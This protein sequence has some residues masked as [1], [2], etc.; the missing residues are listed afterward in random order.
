M[1]DKVKGGL[2]VKTVK[3]FF[4]N[5]LVL[6]LTSVFMRF[7]SVVFNV[8]I[9][10]RIGSAGMGLFSLILSVYTF[11]TTLATSGIYLACTR[12]VT[13]ELVRN[14]AQGVKASM[15]KCIIYSLCF[16]TVSFLL[17]FCFAEKIALF[18]LCDIRALRSL[19]LLAVS[20]PFFAL[21]S[22]LSGYFCAVRRVV[23]NALTNI[24]EQFIRI[25][26]TV[27]LLVNTTCKNVEQATVAV[28]IGMCASEILAFLASFI[29]FVAD[30]KKN[31]SRMPEKAS[32][33]IT[34]RL[35]KMSIP[36]ALSAYIR[37][38][39][40]TVENILIP[41]GLIRSGAATEQALSSYG[42]ISGMVFPVIFFP[43]AFLSA[44]SSLVVPEI[45]RY[46]E[47][48][49]RKQIDYVVGRIFKI[50]AVFSVG[51]AGIFIFFSD[52]LGLLLYNSEQA[53]RYIKIF[54]ALIPVMYIDNTTDAV[55][56]GMGEQISS[57]RYNIIDALVSVLL[58]YFLLPPLGIKGYVAVI[59]IS[60]LLNASL[61]LQRMLRITKIKI[62]PFSCIVS[63]L[64][65]IIG[66]TS[67][68]NIIKV[69]YKF[70]VVSVTVNIILCLIL[71]FSFLRM[72][73]GVTSEEKNWFLNI[74]ASKKS[75]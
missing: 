23:K 32:S 47:K 70:D 46:N 59:Y 42:V 62:K 39:L 11:A 55:L 17:L 27:M 31:S 25:F 43:V 6:T 66:A 53:G 19:R 58:V 18:W 12:L 48:G 57:M 71:Y 50:T 64:L 56:K 30:M 24:L 67:A 49:Q 16:G 51:I 38:A 20:L 37:S 10:N 7:I 61:S 5:G 21:S 33:G 13:Q 29:L 3:R 73:G 54:A 60:E 45:T 4:L 14:S 35:L 52:S 69:S 9:T 36:V 74:F 28:V 41:K 34:I 63:P 65:S 75:E 68:V 22:A 8:Y 40:V 1:S 44:F 72:T 15:K 2:Y 26:L